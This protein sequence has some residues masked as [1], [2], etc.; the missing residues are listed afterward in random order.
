MGRLYG[1]E[2]SLAMMVME[3]WGVQVSDGFGC[4]D[5]GHAVADD[6]MPQHICPLWPHRIASGGE[7]GHEFTMVMDT[8]V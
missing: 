7:R 3:L 4:T 5:T 2:V 6:N 1:G 8:N